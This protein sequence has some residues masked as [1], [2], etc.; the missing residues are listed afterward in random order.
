MPMSELTKALNA[1]VQELDAFCTKVDER[2]EDQVEGLMK[3]A[4]DF[5]E[6]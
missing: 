2:V 6:Y 3:Y 5:E 1:V 4:V